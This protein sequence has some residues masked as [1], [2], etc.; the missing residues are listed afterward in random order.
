MFYF[1]E[2]FGTLS[3]SGWGISVSK[4]LTLPSLIVNLRAW[5]TFLLLLPG[6]GPLPGLPRAITWEL[7]K[8]PYSGSPPATGPKWG[9]GPSSYESFLHDANMQVKA[10][11]SGDKIHSCML[12]FWP[13]ASLAYVGY[14]GLIPK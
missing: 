7:S 12:Q 3:H 6:S 4:D 13:V 5:C 10:L 11:A 9:L 14:L 8:A 1:Q 2:Y